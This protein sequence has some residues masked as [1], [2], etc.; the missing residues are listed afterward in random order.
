MASSGLLWIAG[1]IIVLALL[2][3]VPVHYTRRRRN[4]TDRRPQ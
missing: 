2:I 4:T 1:W 3:G